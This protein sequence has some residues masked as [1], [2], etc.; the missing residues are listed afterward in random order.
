M[1]VHMQVRNIETPCMY[2]FAQMWLRARSLLHMLQANVKA[3]GNEAVSDLLVNDNTDGAGG[4]V[5]HA[6]SAAVIEL[7]RHT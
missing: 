2:D 4:N 5:P 1:W 6:S 7:V 3:L